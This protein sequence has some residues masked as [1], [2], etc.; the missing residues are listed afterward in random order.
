MSCWLLCTPYCG[1]VLQP[2][3]VPWL[4][5]EIT[6]LWFTGWHSIHWATPAR[7]FFFF[8]ILTQ[9]HFFI[10]FQIERRE[11]EKHLCEREESVGYLL[12]APLPGILSAQTGN[13][14]HPDQDWTGNLGMCHDQGSNLWSSVTGCTTQAGAKDHSLNHCI[15][16]FLGISKSLQI[17]LPNEC[18]KGKGSP[19][20]LRSFL[21]VVQQVP[22]P[23]SGWNLMSFSIH[24]SW[25]VLYFDR[26]FLFL[27]WLLLL[28]SI[29]RDKTKCCSY[30]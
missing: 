14:I 26:K 13:C 8:V 23:L 27:Q 2:R 3:H 5:I 24:Y 29:P 21:R 6:T 16:G 1:P 30:I 28:A 4:G 10:A 15:F 11:R 19:G 22:H 17:H 12:D 7:A 9:G 20:S 18:T 25:Q